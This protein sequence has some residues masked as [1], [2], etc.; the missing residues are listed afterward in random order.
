MTDHDAQTIDPVEKPIYDF[1]TYDCEGLLGLMLVDQHLR[2]AAF[3]TP[4]RAWFYLVAQD[5]AHLRA[6]W[7]WTTARRDQWQVW[8]EIARESVAAFSAHLEALIKAEP[9]TPPAWGFT[10]GRDPAD[11]RRLILWEMVDQADGRQG[12][13][14]IWKRRFKTVAACD[15]AHQW[16]DRDEN[17]L[18]WEP[19]A[20][21]VRYQGRKVADALVDRS[22]A[23]QRWC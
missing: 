14:A 17:M 8:G 23:A 6:I 3:D 20:D 18:E 7:D 2:R 1:M 21:V 5:R 10:L 15:R 9:L 12:R 19:L 11:R 22:V 13:V 16:L 4:T